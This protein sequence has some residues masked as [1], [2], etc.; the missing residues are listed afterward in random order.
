MYVCQLTAEKNGLTA[1]MCGKVDSNM[2]D[3]YIKDAKGRR[4]VLVS[5]T[6]DEVIIKEGW[7][8]HYPADHAHQEPAEIEVICEIDSVERYVASD[9]L[10]DAMEDDSLTKDEASLIEELIVNNQ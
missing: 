7:E 6:Y 10:D 3:F 2:W 9:E 4:K 5:F 8:V 1:T